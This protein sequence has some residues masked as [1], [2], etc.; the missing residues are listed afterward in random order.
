M[1]P[2][3]GV[4]TCLISG[5]FRDGRI[6]V[7]TAIDRHPRERGDRRD[8]PDLALLRSIR[9]LM[10]L[11]RNA[12]RCSDFDQ[13]FQYAF[14]WIARRGQASMKADLRRCL[15]NLRRSKSVK[16]PPMPMPAR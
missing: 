5:L 14:G 4:G 2:S 9:A 12:W 15:A 7:M 8:K 13:A 10:A 3:G 11:Q 1:A 6:A 16:V